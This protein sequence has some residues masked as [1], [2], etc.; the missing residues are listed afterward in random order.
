MT[1]RYVQLPIDSA[2]ELVSAVWLFHADI[3]RRAD[4]GEFLAK[5][6]M[7]QIR[8][9]GEDCNSQLDL[10][11]RMLNSDHARFV[12]WNSTER[13]ILEEAIVMHAEYFTEKHGAAKEAIAAAQKLVADYDA[14]TWKDCP[15]K[16]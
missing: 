7:L 13:M 2:R 5:C 16:D 11:D 14:A 3:M 1:A 15:A 8:R 4:G 6:A 12:A 10:Y 9:V